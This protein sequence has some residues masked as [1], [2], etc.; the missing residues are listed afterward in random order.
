LFNF[1]ATTQ[2]ILDSVTFLACHFGCKV[3]MFVSYDAL[4]ITVHDGTMFRTRIDT[5][6][7]VAGINLWGLTRVSK[8]LHGLSQSQSSARDFE[9][10]LRKIRDTPLIHSIVLQVFAAGCAGARFCIVNGGDPASWVCSFLAAACIF[11]IR[12]PLAAC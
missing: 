7:G 5:S 2:R 1:G 11:A 10:A 4:L 3:E 8:L 9:Y 6:R 12:R